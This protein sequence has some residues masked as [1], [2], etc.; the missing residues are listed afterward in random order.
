MS[1]PLKKTNTNSLQWGESYFLKDI[2]VGS[3]IYNVELLP[4]KGSVIARSAGTYCILLKTLSN[5]KSIIKLPS[6]Q[7]IEVNSNCTANLGQ[8]SNSLFRSIILGKA[9]AAR[10][11]GRRP[12]TRGEAMNAVD[13]PHGG[14][15][16]GPGGLNNQPRNRWGKLAKW[17]PKK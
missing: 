4:G 12:R 3:Y 5:N 17:Q 16:H 13:H 14:K 15:N 11:L 10:W 7:V 6:N 9:G 2:P 1:D 8:V